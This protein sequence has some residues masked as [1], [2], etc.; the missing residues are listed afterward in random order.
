[1]FETRLL[2]TL[3]RLNPERP[4]YVEAESRKIGTIQI[5]NALLE[6][7]RTG[8]CINIEAPLEARVD[9]LLGDYDY[10]L[11][12]PDWLNSL[13]DELRKLQS[14]ETIESW[15]AYANCAQWRT[16]VY[17]LLEQHY[18]P[19]YLRSQNRN[20]TGFGASRNLIA[21]DLT[22]AGIDALVRQI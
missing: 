20:F 6:T 18:D 7:M 4:V 19:L 21:S 16:L 15:Q 8:S 12:S 22:A 1:M 11:R 2:A 3:Q 13:L 14:R 17:E 5:P 9:F 10:F